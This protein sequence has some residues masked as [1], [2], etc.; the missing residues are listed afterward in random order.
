MKD[1]P[2]PVNITMGRNYGGIQTGQDSSKGK[3]EDVRNEFVSF[4]FRVVRCLL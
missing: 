2:L 4:G 3:K 1:N